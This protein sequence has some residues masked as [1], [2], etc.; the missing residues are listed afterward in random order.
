MSTFN[1]NDILG[2]LNDVQP[3]A[4]AELW[5][6]AEVWSNVSMYRRRDKWEVFCWSNIRLTTDYEDV[7]VYTDRNSAL[8]QYQTT[9]D[10]LVK[11]GAQLRAERN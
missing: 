3:G 10:A 2:A 7:L 11:L 9:R 5:W 8:V 1:F 4:F 6:N